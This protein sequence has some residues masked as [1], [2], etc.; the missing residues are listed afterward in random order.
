MKPRFWLLAAIL[1]ALGI[2]RHKPRRAGRL[3]GFRCELCGHVEGDLDGFDQGSGFVAPLRRVFDRDRHETTRT[4][5][6]E[7]GGRW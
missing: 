5:A 3:G 7:R 1:C 2:Y 6:L 4:T